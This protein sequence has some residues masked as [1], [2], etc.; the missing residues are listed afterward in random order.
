VLSGPLESGPLLGLM[1]ATV[2]TLLAPE[3]TVS[4]AEPG[5]TY[6]GTKIFM[7]SEVVG[8]TS[9]NPTLLLDPVEEGLVVGAL[10]GALVEGAGVALVVGAGV[11]ALVGALVEGAGVALVVGAA[12]GALVGAEVAL[13]VGAGVALVVGAGVALVVG[14]AEGALVAAA[15]VEE[16]EEDL[17]GGEHGELTTSSSATSLASCS[18]KATSSS[19]NEFS[20]ANDTSFASPCGTSANTHP[21]IRN[22]AKSTSFNLNIVLQVNNTGFVN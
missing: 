7:G 10:V 19:I 15:E 11:G 2:A 22:I 17:E 8:T 14:A 4:Q 12:V 6:K 13:V 16:E 3:A 21:I 18:V 5:Y 1:M 9:H 20:A